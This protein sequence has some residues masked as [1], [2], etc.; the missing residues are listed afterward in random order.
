VSARRYTVFA[1]FIDQASR[2][3][4]PPHRFNGG[5]GDPKEVVLTPGYS[6]VAVNLTISRAER[7]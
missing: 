2:L 4:N 6:I 1:L 3:F 7:M 5:V